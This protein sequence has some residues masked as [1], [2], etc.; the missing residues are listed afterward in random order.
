MII[1][2]NLYTSPSSMPPSD[3]C[4]LCNGIELILR[5]IYFSFA[6][7]IHHSYHP[8]GLGHNLQIVAI[9]S[10]PEKCRTFF[11]D[12]FSVQTHWH[13]SFSGAE[14]CDYQWAVLI[15]GMHSGII[16]VRKTEWGS[17]H[18]WVWWHLTLIGFPFGD[19]LRH[20]LAVLAG[21]FSLVVK[22]HYSFIQQIDNSISRR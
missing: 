22:S 3:G 15:Q 18:S 21:E 2:C 8:S 17:N 4:L 13:P 10:Q 7:I 1:C 12:N 19:F 5:F 20:T 11:R 16:Q 6:G 9:S 14:S